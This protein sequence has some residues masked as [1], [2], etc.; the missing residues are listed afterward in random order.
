MIITI[1]GAIKF[2]DEMIAAQKI[3]EKSGHKIYMPKNVK[4]VNY[5]AKDNA[6][7]VEA[8]KNFNEPV[9]KL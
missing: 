9:S 2:M 7:R 6:S 1:C 5:W 4:G 3:L 8:K